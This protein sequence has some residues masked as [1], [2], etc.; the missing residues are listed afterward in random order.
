MNNRGFKI[1]LVD[2]RSEIAGCYQG[3]PQN[4]IGLR[5]DVLD[6]CPKADG[7]MMLIRSMSPQII[8]TDEI[9][10]KEDINAIEEALNAGIRLITT[11]HGKDVQEI[12]R[13]PILNQLVSQNIFDRYIIMTNQPKVGTVQEIIDTSTLKPLRIYSTL[14][15]G[16]DFD[17]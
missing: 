13:R 6:A 2:E 8:A 15:G 10:K 14:K 17:R 9:G 3:I 5:T 11:V 4:D 16:K 7:I 1:G 12:S